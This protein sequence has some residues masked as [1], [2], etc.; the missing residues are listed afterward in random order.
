MFKTNLTKCI[1]NLFKKKVKP[2]DKNKKYC[3]DCYYS[4]ECDTCNFVKYHKI[5]IVNE[6]TGFKDE[7]YP[8]RKVVHKY[9]LKNKPDTRANR[10]WAVCNDDEKK[11]LNSNG[12]CPF[13]KSN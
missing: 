7:T 12:E 2:K 8:K 1:F 10:L 5:I 3:D 6:F 4:G 11:Y 9:L 13:F